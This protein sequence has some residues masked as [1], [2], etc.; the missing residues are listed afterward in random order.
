MAARRKNDGERI[1]SKGNNDV[2]LL[3]YGPAGAEKPGLLD[4]NVLMIVLSD[5]LSRNYS[6]ATV[7]LR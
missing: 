7:R 1:T 3:R 6:T 2:K 5:W 4:V